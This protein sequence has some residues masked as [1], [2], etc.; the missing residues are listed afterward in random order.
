MAL[1]AAPIAPAAEAPPAPHA[2]TM[3]VTSP[4]VGSEG[5]PATQ[6]TNETAGDVKVSV[7]HHSITIDGKPLAYTA[8]A[9]ELTM[10]NES[11][12]PTANMF[13]VAY[14]KGAPSTG[15]ATQE[16]DDSARP[17]TFCFNGGP[18]AAS[19]W[20]HLGAVGPQTVVLDDHG[21]P[22]GPPFRLA[23]NPDTWLASTDLVFVD[24]VS[25]GY[26]RPAKGQDAQQFHGAREDVESVGDFIRLYLTK[27]QRWASP[28][29]LAGESYG[30][31]R[32]A[33]LSKYLAERYGISVNGIVL[34]SSVLDFQE[35]ESGGVND[36]PYALFLPS[37]AAVA[38]YHHKLDA[39]WQAD[40]Q[41][42][43]DAARA[44]TT[45][46]YL[47][48]LA[49]GAA[50][51]P[52]QR[53]AVIA[54]LS[55]FTSLS[56]DLIDRSNLRI[57]PFL[58]EKSLL[59]GHPGHDIIGRFDGRITGYDPDAIS[60]QP[61][62]DP[63]ETR[64]FPAYAATFNEY[65]RH[66]LD[67]KSDLPYEVLTDRVWPWNFGKNNNGYLDV[68]DDLQTALVENPH[69]RVMFVSGYFDLATPFFSAD[70]TIDRLNLPLQLRANVSHVYF[71]AGHMVYHEAASKRGLADDVARFVET[72]N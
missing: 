50:L 61:S 5:P 39:Q 7:T 41:K 35:L 21:L 40:L 9:G 31:T 55:A 46:V 59:D 69:M 60:P 44:F 54:Q 26:S 16:S 42:T 37:Y 70:Y 48:A 17:I 19:V 49:K 30:T 20:L 1:A 12:K 15:P 22:V 10:K 51:D 67:Y 25:T 68:L 27:Y 14:R 71:P 58:F 8:T 52:K 72:R 45:D 38:W 24:P 13:F 53:A 33:A 18:G 6:P 66:V 62:Y 36:L 56:A 57:D 65:A 28:V 3:P 64:Y 2:A 23:D 43:V 47:P 4:P 34:I 11:D 32:A 29:Y 63:S